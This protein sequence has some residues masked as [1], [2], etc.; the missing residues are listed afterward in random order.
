MNSTTNVWARGA[1]AAAALAALSGCAGPLPKPALAEPLAKQASPAAE[2]YGK[3]ASSEAAKQAAALAAA[4]VAIEAPKPPHAPAA[5]PRL[6]LDAKGASPYPIFERILEG[7]GMTVA[8]SAEA[9]SAPITLRL[10]DATWREALDTL[11][12][13]KGY[14]YKIDGRRVVVSKPER[15]TRVFD[16]SY[17]ANV[18]NGASEVRVESG[19]S[20][21]TQQS[22]GAGAGL[23]G[24][25]GAQ[26]AGAQGGQ[27]GAGQSSIKSSN[28]ED[29][30]G[31]ARANLKEIVGGKDNT[32]AINEMAGS[33]FVRAE[34]A[35]VAEVEAYLTALQESIGRQVMIEAKII[36]V[37]LSET[38]QEG[39]NWS[40]FGGGST[41]LG[42]GFVPNG[43][44]VSPGAAITASTGAG[45]S[46]SGT[47]TF[48]PGSLGLSGLLGGSA[49]GLAIQAKNFAA[50]INF[51][52]TQGSV[53]VLSS[54]R[55]A[56]MNNR[57]SLLKIGTDDI[58]VTG[59]QSTTTTSTTGTSSAPTVMT[60]QYFS[61]IALDVLAQIAAD[62]SVIINGHPQIS[63]VT[64]KVVGIN[65]GSQ[66]SISYPTAS[67]AINETDFMVKLDSGS[68]AV[69]GGL[70]RVR[71]E[72][73][74][75]KVPGLGDLPVVGALARDSTRTG[76]K[77]EV[78]ILLKATVIK[79]RADWAAGA[80]GMGE[81][82]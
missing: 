52:E 59:V 18:R 69:I 11:R 56:A 38:H 34:P 58:F 47:L 35:K 44:A 27:A 81:L 37:A 30:W 14:A 19:N 24:A 21:S 72:E 22:A 7:S 76:A 6:D 33:V 28:K 40:A 10:R 66:G 1:I 80:A 45:G 54:P 4:P 26:Q 8:L 65:L 63:S 41:A 55:I 75:S 17:L 3:A 67:N 62:G 13:T 53:R 68:I 23:G 82:Q 74:G 49:A 12:D 70:M 57:K 16:L 29:F 25:G 5:L 15:I 50:M 60:A 20:G 43:G 31:E 77:T 51:L 64:Q 46:G 48:S 42:A 32:V 9:E 2:I 39:V 36:E 78:I 61:G 71:S 73:A 79:T